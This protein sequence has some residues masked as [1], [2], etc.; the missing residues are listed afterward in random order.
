MSSMN[1]ETSLTEAKL[2]SAFRMLDQ[3]GNGNLSL[4]E[5]KSVLGP[6]IPTEVYSVIVKEFDKN[7]NGEVPLS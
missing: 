5:F 6:N 2:E 7:K 4:D 3:D 1:I